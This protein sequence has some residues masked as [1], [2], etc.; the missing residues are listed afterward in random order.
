MK[1]RHLSIVMAILAIAMLVIAGCENSTPSP[2][3]TRGCT[4]SDALNYNYEADT[5]DGSCKFST[6]TFYAR[7]SHFSGIP[8]SGISVMVDGETIGSLTVYYPNGPGN[9]SAPGTARYTFHNSGSVDWNTVALLANGAR[10]TGS[11]TVE[12]RSSAACI[13]VNVT[14]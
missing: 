3:P 6:V 1:I 12:P 5:D 8:I 9:C 11:G 10:V 13:R 4:D 14:R 2:P 7:Y